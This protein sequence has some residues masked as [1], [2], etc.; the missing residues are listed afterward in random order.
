MVIILGASAQSFGP[1]EEAPT[2]PLVKTRPVPHIPS[3][4]SRAPSHPHP[5]SS[6]VPVTVHAPWCPMATSDPPRVSAVPPVNYGVAT[7]HLTGEF[8]ALWGTL[9]EVR[10]CFGALLGKFGCIG[11]DSGHLRGL[12]GDFGT[13]SA[14]IVNK[15]G[16]NKTKPLGF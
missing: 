10:G 5:P 7:S 6:M 8:W 3:S 15:K 16:E 12:W 9:G 1:R 4:P 13:K 14:R 11:G 2:A